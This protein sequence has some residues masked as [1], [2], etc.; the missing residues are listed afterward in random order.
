MDDDSETNIPVLEPCV[1][2]TDLDEFKQSRIELRKLILDIKFS[3]ERPDLFP[4]GSLRDVKIL[5]Y[6]SSNIDLYHLAI[7]VAK[8]VGA[9]FIPV[10]CRESQNGNE[11]YMFLDGPNRIKAIFS[12]AESSAPCVILLNNIDGIS[13]SELRVFEKSSQRW[14]LLAELDVCREKRREGVIV[15]GTTN[16]FELLDVYIYGKFQK[17]IE[18]K[19]SY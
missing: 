9:K 5:L 19:P 2:L 11:K 4:L 12:K 16:R 8:E 18:I 17:Q 6:S 3:F 10:E 13:R 7:A 15:V 14:Q 1:S